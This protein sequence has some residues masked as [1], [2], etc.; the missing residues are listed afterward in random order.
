[1]SLGRDIILNTG[2][3]IFARVTSTLLAA[4]TLGVLTR[5]L[6][7]EGYGAFTIAT[8]FPQLFGIFADFGLSLIAIQMISEAGSNHVRNYHAIITLRCIIA[9]IF[10]GIAPLAA[11]FFPYSFAIKLG[12][13]I[14]AASVFI[15]SLIQIFTVQFQVNLAMIKPM[16]AEI[17]SKLFLIAGIGFAVLMQ[18]DLLVILLLI[19]INNVIQLAMLFFWSLRYCPP[20]FVWD[21][22]VF[23]EIGMRSWPI[24]LSIIFNLVYLKVDTIILSLYYPEK[25][26]GIYGGAYKVFEVLL[27]YPSLFMGIVLA[28]FSRSW[29]RGDHLSFQRYFQKSFDF[30]LLSA[31]PIMVCTPFIARPLLILILGNEFEASADILGVLTIAAGFVFFG[32]FFGHLINVIHKQKIMLVGYAAGAILGFAGYLLTIPVFSYWG[33]AGTTVG[34]EL[35]VLAVSAY[36]FLHATR[37]SVNFENAKRI[38]LA[39]LAITLFL[40]M[41]LFFSVNLMVVFAGTAAI[42]AGIL[43][44]FGIIPKNLINDLLVVKK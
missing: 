32:S 39:T 37:L 11:L 15:S 13:A 34:V 9:F 8:T 5:Y 28:S 35:F 4:I 44:V 26:V 25:I 10:C 42:Y 30:M 17:V 41:G 36:I 43:Y 22:T 2:I 7:A 33:A 29:S 21:M 24:G 19:V 14:V 27:T 23:K 6:Q 12:I 18:W 3:Q 38:V 20:R 1:M 31:L 40:G 16:I